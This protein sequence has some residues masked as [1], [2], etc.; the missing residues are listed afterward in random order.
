VVLG[1]RPS[2]LLST[3]AGNHLANTWVSAQCRQGVGVGRSQ[4]G[5]VSGSFPLS[6]P[7]NLAKRGTFCTLTIIM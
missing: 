7:L 2:H 6:F 1:G 4:V 5:A 3:E